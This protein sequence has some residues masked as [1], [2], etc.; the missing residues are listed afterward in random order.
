M[1]SPAQIMLADTHTNLGA[2]YILSTPPR[3]D[4]ALEHLQQALML[5]P[6][7]GEVSFEIR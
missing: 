6:E 5:S 2:A 4:K 1:L 7:D 3:P